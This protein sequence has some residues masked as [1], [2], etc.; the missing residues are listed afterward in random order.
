MASS[1]RNSTSSLR[2][3]SDK[4]Q[5]ARRSA[6]G[7]Y[8]SNGDLRF[9]GVVV[10]NTSSDKSQFSIKICFQLPNLLKLVM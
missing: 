7:G 8:K 3:S 2:N 4:K 5:H 1:P 10:Y 9:V 6:C